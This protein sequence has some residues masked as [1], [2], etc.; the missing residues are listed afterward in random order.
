[1]RYSGLP[2]ADACRRANVASLAAAAGSS[3]S[4]SCS[5]NVSSIGASSI[6]TSS[7]GSQPPGRRVITTHERG[8]EHAADNVQHARDASSSQCT[9]STTMTAPIA[10]DCD[11]QLGDDRRAAGRRGMLGRARRPRR[12]HRTSA[13][14]T[15]AIRGSHASELRTA[16]STKARE[17]RAG[18]PIVGG[19]VDAE[20]TS[21]EPPERQVRRRRSCGSARITSHSR[22]ALATLR[23]S[24]QS[25]LLPTPASPTSSTVRPIGWRRAAARA[26]RSRPT[27]VRR[28]AASMWPTVRRATRAP[29]RA[30]RTGSSLPLDEE[31][32]ERRPLR[33]ALGHVATSRSPAM[34]S[35]GS[36]W[37]HQPGGE[38]GGVAHD[39]VGA[40]LRDGPCRR[41]TRRRGWR[42]SAV[43]A[44][45]SSAIVAD[46]AQQ[47]F[48]VAL[49]RRRC[50]GDQ[51][52]SAPS[53]PPPGSRASTR[54]ARPQVRSTISVISP[55]TA[56][57]RRDPRRRADRRCR[58]A[59]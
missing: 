22:P 5:A 15:S 1:M 45:D 43:G 19:R 9:S 3:R 6:V 11:D 54:R 38:V 14:T 57:T 20:P 51:A 39:D 18:R 47:A 10:R 21:D 42:R 2:A 59:G 17:R 58:R 37:R 55:S 30:A 56:N 7:G 52:S 26:R 12:W 44:G 24:C 32:L 49:G 46:D 36:A 33:T 29:M 8:A 16:L 48:T 13:P 23:A 4:S 50:T 25:L 35:P 27:T 28:Q 31:R 40:A 53:W 34:I 41:R